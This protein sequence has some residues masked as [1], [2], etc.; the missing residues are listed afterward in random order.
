MWE[1]FMRW[2]DLREDVHVLR[3]LDDRMLEDMGLTRGEIRRRV[4]AGAGA[5]ERPVAQDPDSGVGGEGV[6][7]PDL[8]GFGGGSV[9]RWTPEPLCV[10]GARPIW[11][12]F[13]LQTGGYN[14][15]ARKPC[16]RI[17]IWQPAPAWRSSKSS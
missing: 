6:P 5:P 13:P 8:L 4:T 10:R 14:R 3:G 1:R 16:K 12:E 11:G 15:L 17:D 9:F 2:W 7:W